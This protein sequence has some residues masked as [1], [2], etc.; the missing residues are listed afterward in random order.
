MTSA[1]P[2]GARDCVCTWSTVATPMPQHFMEKSEQR[3]GPCH[4]LLVFLVKE[5]HYFPDFTGSSWRKLLGS[6]YLATG[7]ES[8]VSALQQINCPFFFPSKQI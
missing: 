6:V 4:M 3:Q 5:Q 1:W 2:L 8:E 7:A